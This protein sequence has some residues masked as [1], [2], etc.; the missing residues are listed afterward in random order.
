MARSVTWL[1]LSDLHTCNPKT[2]WDAHRVLQPLID[3]LKLMQQEHGLQ[4]ELLFFTGDLALGQLGKAAGLKLSHQLK[5]GHEFLGQVRSAF[6]REIPRENVFLVPGNHDVNRDAVTPEQTFWQDTQADVAAVTDLIR[7]K[8]KQWKRIMERLSMYRIL[9]EKY[10]YQHLLK[11]PDRLIYAEPLSVGGSRIGVAGLNSAWSCC[12]DDEKGRLWLGGNWQLGELASKLRDVDFRIA[13]I[14]HPASW[15]NEHE[16][17]AIA[18][19][20]ARDFRFCLHGHEHQGWINDWPNEHTRIASAACY[21]SSGE[22]NGYNFVHLNLDEGNGQVWL[23][24]YDADGG[25]W[26]PRV[27]KG[28]T[29]NDGKWRLLQ[30]PK[31]PRR[32]LPNLVG[33][34]RIVVN[35][36]GTIRVCMSSMET[37]EFPRSLPDTTIA[38][39]CSKRHVAKAWK[40]VHADA[41]TAYALFGLVYSAM[42]GYRQSGSDKQ[43]T[44]ASESLATAWEK[45]NKFCEAIPRLH[46]DVKKADHIKVMCQLPET[47]HAVQRGLA[48]PP[49][50]DDFLNTL[51]FVG[52][53][54]DWFFDCLHRADQCLAVYF[55]LGGTE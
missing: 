39:Q 20:V 48:C 41:E 23:R 31:L 25:G 21:E 45:L 27:I 3:D 12:R 4:P 49:N 40:Q 14:H 33:Y 43:L 29:D 42:E 44:Q 5:A 11:D 50:E 55:R 28:K 8:K 36:H 53:I 22:E 18:R 10:G 24:R 51:R 7:Q 17:P 30:T 16:D 52:Q 34:P 54:K 32:T 15:F 46:A 38:S 35:R 1:H 6:E 13:L 37:I 47:I 9:L 19:I 26:I 2:G